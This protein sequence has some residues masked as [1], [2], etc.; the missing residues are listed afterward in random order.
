MVEETTVGFAKFEVLEE[1]SFFLDCLGTHNVTS[2]Y[3]LIVTPQR[4]MGQRSANTVHRAGNRNETNCIVQ[5]YKNS[6][7]IQ[8]F[9]MCRGYGSTL[10]QP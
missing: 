2:R 8:N 1:E 6:Q 3:G 9:R 7:Q 4:V 10:S 5:I